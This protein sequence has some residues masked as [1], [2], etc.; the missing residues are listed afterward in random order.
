MNEPLQEFT[1]ISRKKREFH[2]RF[3]GCV[4][5]CFCRATLSNANVRH[6]LHFGSP[7]VRTRNTPCFDFRRVQ[8]ENLSRR[9]QG[10]ELINTAD[11]IT[12][13]VSLQSSL[14]QMRIE[15]DS[16]QLTSDTGRPVAHK[17]EPPTTP[18]YRSHRLAF[19]FGDAAHIPNSNRPIAA[20]GGDAMSD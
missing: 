4:Q 3:V 5:P 14:T 2:G 17:S 11:L 10:T 16:R 20:A 8:R 13:A 9:H 19:I 15:T 18:Q 7:K 6:S 12:S 1:Y